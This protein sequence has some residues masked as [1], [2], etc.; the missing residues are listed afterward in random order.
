MKEKLIRD[1]QQEH[2][3]AEIAKLKSGNL[4]PRKS[5]LYKNHPQID[6]R[7]ILKVVGRFAPDRV[8]KKLTVLPSRTAL[9]ALII[10]DVHERE[11]GHIGSVNWNANQVKKTY[12]ILRLGIMVRKML[13]K[14]YD[15]ARRFP[16]PFKQTMSPLHKVRQP[17]NVGEGE[18]PFA[19]GG[20][21]QV[22]FA[23]PWELSLIHI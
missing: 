2:F 11:L 7:G 9:T 4:V 22:D 23:G 5:V 12:W 17:G 3:P 20:T 15:C 6:E 10:K 19:F 16:E 18:T 13:S 1:L 21:I 8:D 14:C